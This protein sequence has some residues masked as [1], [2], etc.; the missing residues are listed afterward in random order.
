V[1]ADERPID[2]SAFEISEDER[3]RLRAARSANIR[4]GTV[5]PIANHEMGPG[6]AIA[7]CLIRGVVVLCPFIAAFAGIGILTYNAGSMAMRAAKDDTYIPEKGSGARLAVIFSELASN[8]SLRDEV[9][10]RL[11]THP[12]SQSE[13]PRL[14]VGIESARLMPVAGGVTL[15]ITARSQLITA[16]DA[17][18]VETT[19]QFTS[20]RR[21][22]DEWLASNGKLF[23]DDLDS[24]FEV[25]SS[26]IA[27]VY[28]PEQVDDARR[29]ASRP[30]GGQ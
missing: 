30:R 7:E 19:H 9:S 4:G 11:L 12:A 17:K 29:A 26:H 20:S 13:F 22:V 5:N 1:I 18:G 15:V 2:V 6:G 10:K 27:A 25:L 3:A 16:P 8:N 24:A 21:D 14:V 23:R 28:K